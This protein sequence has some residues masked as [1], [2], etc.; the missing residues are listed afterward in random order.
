MANIIKQYSVGELL[1]GR[2]FFIPAYQRGYRWTDKQV[3][4]LL[5]D[6]LTFANDKK[7]EG[8]FYCLQPIIARPITD[9]ERL[10]DIIP[11]ESLENACKKGVWEIIDGQQRLTTLYLI[12]KYIVD[13]MGLTP[14]DLLE[15]TGRELYHIFYATRDE[16]ASFLENTI[17]NELLKEDNCE[18]YNHNVDFFHMAGAFKSI[19]RWI[20]E[21]GRIIKERYKEDGNLRIIRDDFFRLLNASRDNRKGSVQ[22]LWYQ[23]DEQHDKN[24]IKEFQEINTGKIRLT[25]AELIKGLFLMSKNFQEGDDIGQ[26]ELALEWEMIE[27]ALHND[28][29]WSFL[30]KRGQDMPNR[31]DLLFSLLYKTGKAVSLPEEEW[32]IRIVEADEE[33]RDPRRSAIFRFFNDRFEGKS[34]AELQKE[35]ATAWQE[36]MELFR[37]L[38]DWYSTPRLY[39]MIGLLSQCGED[40]SRLILF[41]NSLPID[42][43]RGRFEAH[44]KDR[45]RHHLSEARVETDGETDKPRIINDYRR[46]GRSIIF[47]LLLALNIQILNG[48]DIASESESD[49]YKFPFEILN[50]NKNGGWDIEHIDSA[51]TNALKREEDKIRWIET[52]IDDCP[53]ELNDEDLHKLEILK[54]KRLY[55]D[56][57]ALLKEKADE[58]QDD[59]IKNNIGNLTLL[60]SKTNRGYGNSLFCTKRRIIIDRIKQGVFVPIGTQYVFSKFF[61]TKGT[62][63]SFWTRKD[64]EEYHDYVYRNLCDYLTKPA[65]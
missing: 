12:Y 47:K 11:A 13:K 44:L 16:S 46:N 21:E 30:Q 45:I 24:A 35:V 34:G 56:A 48:Q 31:I 25:D 39:N 52:A 10:K 7:K 42:T 2:Y 18:K 23:L 58:E 17:S 63:R 41:F 4:D 20:K 64:M 1:D 9:P 38:D 37:T 65:D 14:E 36:V 54:E 49:I 28:S 51:H 22:V 57:I 53:A 5:R 43:D 40:L 3:G 50:D 29:F 55:D 26:A 59:E 61:D 33:I 27:N 32:D 6:L 62:N 60:D 19:D 15:E 8:D